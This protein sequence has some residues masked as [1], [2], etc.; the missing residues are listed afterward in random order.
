MS[1][2]QE[3]GGLLLTENTYSKYKLFKMSKKSKRS[4][5]NVIYY[6]IMYY[7]IFM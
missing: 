7:H 3:Q 5:P 4:S 2:I 1:L 6:T